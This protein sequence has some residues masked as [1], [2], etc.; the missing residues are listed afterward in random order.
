MFEGVSLLAATCH[1][2]QL[3]Q[4]QTSRVRLA[5][6]ARATEH[7]KHKLLHVHEKL[8][9]A[10]PGYNSLNDK[11]LRAASLLQ[12]LHGGV[13]NLLQVVGDGLV[14]KPGRAD[15]LERVE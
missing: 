4:K 5:T 15:R 3:T 11:T 2:E 8:N 10:I 9:R 12:L 6:S 14:E 7:G 13:D 1:V